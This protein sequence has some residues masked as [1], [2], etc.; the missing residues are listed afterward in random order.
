LLVTLLGA[1]LYASSP[2]WA[3]RA[4]RSELHNRENPGKLAARLDLERLR[5]SLKAQLQ[6]QLAA[7]ERAMPVPGTAQAVIGRVGP[8]VA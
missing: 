1:G 3:I 4:L 2:Y 8:G 5:D 7:A 6:E